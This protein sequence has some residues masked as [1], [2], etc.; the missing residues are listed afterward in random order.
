[1]VIKGAD[2][3]SEHREAMRGGPGYVDIL[4][5]VGADNLPAKSRL[6]SLIT[7]EKDCGIG[8]HAHS[9]ETEIYYVLGGEGVLD[10]NGQLKPFAKGDSN[11]CNDGET[12]AVTNTKDETMRIIAVIIK[13]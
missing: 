8:P 3:Q 9:G 7:L 4:H 12:H 10:D 1:M 5:I 13:N 11:V 2:M 6:F